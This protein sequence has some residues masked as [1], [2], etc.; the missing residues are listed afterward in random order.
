[1]TDS[2]IGRAWVSDGREYW[3]TA[4]G[5]PAVSPFIARVDKEVGEVKVQ[6]PEIDEIKACIVIAISEFYHDRLKLGQLMTMQF[7]T[8]RDIKI[9][10]KYHLENV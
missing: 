7:D 6:T 3:D 5:H 4:W 2:F 1:M 10:L 8:E 9:I